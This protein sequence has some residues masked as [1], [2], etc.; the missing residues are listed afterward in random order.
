MIFFSNFIS[1]GIFEPN[2]RWQFLDSYKMTT[3]LS[4]TSHMRRTLYTLFHISYETVLSLQV[5]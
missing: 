3:D 5:K 4:L 2:Q 1:S